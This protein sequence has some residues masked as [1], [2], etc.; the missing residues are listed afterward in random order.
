[1]IRKEKSL[2]NVSVI[3]ENV[4][5][6]LVPDEV[7]LKKKKKPPDK[8]YFYDKIRRIRGSECVLEGIIVIYY[9]YSQGLSMILSE[10]LVWSVY[11]ESRNQKFKTFK[12]ILRGFSTIKS[13][14]RAI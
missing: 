12:V 9:L 13:V 2:V 1:M 4:P 11:Q 3:N 8:A 10:F 7:V 14:L 5:D 6:F